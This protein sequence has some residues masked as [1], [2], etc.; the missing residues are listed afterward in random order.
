MRRLVVWWRAQTRVLWHELPIS[1]QIIGFLQVEGLHHIDT[2]CACK[3]LRDH[4][5]RAKSDWYS[6]TKLV[7]CILWRNS[8]VTLVRSS[9]SANLD[10]TENRSLIKKVS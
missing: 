7:S 9:E 8:L 5:C 6:S 1:V 3:D 10:V 2:I 4:T